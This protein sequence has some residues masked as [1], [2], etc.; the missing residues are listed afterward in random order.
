MIL[1]L[2]SADG[3]M[4]VRLWTLSSLDGRRPPWY[5]PLV[6][7]SCM[8]A[9]LD[10]DGTELGPFPVL[11]I[12]LIFS[13]GPWRLCWSWFVRLGGVMVSWMSLDGRRPPWHRPLGCSGHSGPVGPLLFQLCSSV[14]PPAVARPASLPLPLRVPE[15]RCPARRML[16]N[17]REWR[18]NASWSGVAYTTSGSK[19]R[20]NARWP[21]R[22]LAFKT[23]WRM[24][25]SYKSF[26]FICFHANFSS[27]SFVDRQNTYSCK[28]D[29]FAN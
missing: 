3:G 19:A 2:A 11:P 5:R 6:S 12:P 7:Q 4:T 20:S 28:S 15:A 26:T 9:W 29:L 24:C 27:F 17:A 10:S 1:G 18:N 16:V 14:S 21:G 23:R 13:L 22:S 8:L 25:F